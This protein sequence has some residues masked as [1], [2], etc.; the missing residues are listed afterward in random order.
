MTMT[1][2]TVTGELTVPNGE[3]STGQVQFTLDKTMRNTV[4]NHIVLPTTVIAPLKDGVFSVEL[5]ATDD[6]GTA[7]SGCKYLYQE[8][9][10]ADL[11]S[12]P[13]PIAL[14]H[15]SPNPVRIEDLL[16]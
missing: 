1:L 5:Y 4:D 12:N 3:S 8:F 16:P 9:L 15:T 13:V 14:P 11:P 10:A 2:I 7:P 6:V